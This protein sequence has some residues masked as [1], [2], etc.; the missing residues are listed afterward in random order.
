MAIAKSARPVVRRRVAL[1]V[2]P[3]T[4]ASALALLATRAEGLP[5]TGTEQAAAKAPTVATAACSPTD[6]GTLG[7]GQGNAIAVSSNGLVAGYAEDASGTPQPVLWRSGHPTRI[8]TG[9][10]NVTP[11][12][13]N[14][15]GEVV[16]TGVDAADQEA[17]GWHWVSGRL[18]RLKAPAGKIAMPAAINDTGRIAGA[19]ASDDDGGAEPT[20]GEAPEQAATW[21]SASASA[22]AL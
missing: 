10:I 19:L 2:V 9:L 14:S 15:R 13:I 22:R 21:A 18:T 7:G 17:V 8:S 16:G 1:A 20:A 11:T 12:G 5:S 3:L 4:V 6:L